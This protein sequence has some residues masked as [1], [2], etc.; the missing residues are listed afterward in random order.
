[1]LGQIFLWIWGILVGTIITMSVIDLSVQGHLHGGS[2]V[3]R[4]DQWGWALVIA[5]L[6]PLILVL[7]PIVFILWLCHLL[8]GILISNVVVLKKSSIKK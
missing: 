2:S 3:E 4:D 1:M 6:F 8:V 7:I 5:I